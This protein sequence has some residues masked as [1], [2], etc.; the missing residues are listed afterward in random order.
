MK[1]LLVSDTH[2]MNENLRKAIE[3][4]KPFDYLIHCGDTDD[5]WREIESMAGT[6]CTF[7]RGNNDYDRALKDTARLFFKGITIYVTHGHRLRVHYGHE[8]L[9]RE[10]KKYGCAIAAYGHTHRPVVDDSDPDL[11]ILNPGSLTY[12]RQPG[13]QPSYIVLTLEKGQKP[14]AE[15]RFIKR[16]EGIRG[17]FY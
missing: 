10:A 15:I 3:R 9:I 1:I 13:R 17:F 11:L 8:G 7:V 2:G 12:P 16:K 14:G 5:E 4:E 6:L